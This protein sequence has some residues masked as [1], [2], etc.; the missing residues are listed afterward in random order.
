MPTNKPG[1][2]DTIPPK[3]TEDPGDGFEWKWHYAIKKWKKVP[4]VIGQFQKQFVQHLGHLDMAD[5]VD[6]SSSQPI[7]RYA[8]KICHMIYL[9]M[10]THIVKT[11][12]GVLRSKV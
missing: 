2:V 1:L 4:K 12:S 7:I 9:G 3:P 6:V 8:G 10:D 11:V 5:S